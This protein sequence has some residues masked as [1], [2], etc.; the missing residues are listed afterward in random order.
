M[1]SFVAAAAVAGEADL[2]VPPADLPADQAVFWHAH[3]PQAVEAQTLVAR[4]VGAMRLLCELEAA[5]Q[6][7]SA[8]LDE[9]G[10]TYIKAWT[11]SSGQEHEELKAHPLT[12]H[13]RQLAQRVEA[14]MARF[15]IAPLGKPVLAGK[16]KSKAANPWA[17]V[18]QKR[19]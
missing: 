6:K 10:L 9:D 5:K 4:T 17:V 13:Y 14:M 8:K 1:A 16:P 12:S 11:D 15:G 2:V 18:G 7:V 19:A 3:A